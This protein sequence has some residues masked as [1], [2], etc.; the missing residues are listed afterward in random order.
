[1]SNHA[2]ETTESTG[3]CAAR[4]VDADAVARTVSALPD[5]DARER[6]ADVFRALADPTRIRLLLALSRE[7]LCVCDLSEVAGVS[8]SAVSHQLRMLRDLRLVAWERD[9]KRAVY[10]LADDHVRDLLAVGLAH[11]EEASPR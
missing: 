8:E 6:L 10:R 9:G 3:E 7:P 4:I 11:A 5:A 1:M 2:D